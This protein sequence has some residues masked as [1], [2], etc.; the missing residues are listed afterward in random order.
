ME[1]HMNTYTFTFFGRQVGAIGSTHHDCVAVQAEDY[2]EAI[3]KL[4]ETH[5]HISRMSYTVFPVK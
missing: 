3:R 4:Y 1:D 2:E 5:E